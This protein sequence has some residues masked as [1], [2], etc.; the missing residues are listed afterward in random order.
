MVG[1]GRRGFV[2]VPGGD[3]NLSQGSPPAP[4]LLGARPKGVSGD[5]EPSELN[6]STQ[7][8]SGTDLTQQRSVGSVVAERYENVA[9]KRCDPRV[10]GRLLV[11]G[12]QPLY[13]TST[14]RSGPLSRRVPRPPAPAPAPQSRDEARG[15]ETRRDRSAC[16]ISCLHPR[17]SNLKPNSG[18]IILLQSAVLARRSRIPEVRTLEKGRVSISWV[19]EVLFDA[20]HVC[21]RHVAC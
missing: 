7:V 6:V 3:S 18:I 5:A 16:P 17:W 21:D 14:Q 2:Q 9:A 8:I 10:G 15:D 1:G 13:P 12:H 19:G 20:D 11:N 4:N